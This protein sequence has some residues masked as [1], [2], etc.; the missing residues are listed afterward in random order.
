ML[1]SML[2]G[3]HLEEEEVAT[4]IVHRHW[5]MGAK[6]LA[7][8]SLSVLA[9]LLLLPFMRVP[10]A[11][12]VVLIWL[13]ASAIWWLRSFFDYYLDAWIIT[14]QGV[15]DLHWHG[16]FHRESSRILYSDVQGVSYEIKGIL[17]TLLRFGTISIEKISTG[18][19]ISLAEIGQPRDVESII[20]KNMEAYLHKKNLKDSKHVQEILAGMVADQMQLKPFD[21]APK[22]AVMPATAP[23]KTRAFQS[24]KI[25][26][27]RS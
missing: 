7:L 6:E 4:A 22:A 15:I 16:W 23:K 8:P 3:K 18:A 2:F 9:S 13:G 21:A 14:N 1:D 26:S 24:S 27:K 17:G 11:Q 19:A 5:L 25:G 20:L 10:A 12:V